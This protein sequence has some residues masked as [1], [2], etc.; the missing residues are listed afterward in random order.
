MLKLPSLEILKNLFEISSTSPSFL[1]WKNPRCLRLKQGDFAGSKNKDGYWQVGI[2]QENKNKLYRVHR[3]IYYLYY[4]INIDSF[5]IDHING[6][7]SD[8]NIMNLRLVT[9][10][11]N[12]WN[13][14][15]QKQHSSKY[16]GVSWDK[17][18]NKWKAQICVNY[19]KMHLGFYDSEIKAA[20]IYNAAAIKHYSSFALIN[21]V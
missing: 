18:M 20:A 7:R 13:K 12:C 4:E 21:N 15:K 2:K 14:Q 9:N 8:N 19:K 16:K 3:I 17:K 5:Q 6:D 11:E 1:L 10:Q